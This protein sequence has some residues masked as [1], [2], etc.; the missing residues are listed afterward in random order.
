MNGIEVVDVTAGYGRR[1]TP[2]RVESGA[3]RAVLA[4][5]SARF[6][7]GTVTAI[8][9]PNGV[10]KTTLLNL[11]LGWMRPWEGAVIVDGRPVATLSGGERGRLLSLVPQSDHVPFEF[12]LLD[13]VLLGRAPHLGPLETPGREDVR[14]ALRALERVGLAD[15][16]AVSVL[17]MSAGERQLVLLARALAQ[18]SAF[19]LLDEPSAHLDLANKRRLVSMLRSLAANGTGVVLTTHEPD[20][21]AAS[22]DRV[23]MLDSGTVLASG[24]PDEVLTGPLLSRAYDTPVTVHRA[25]GRPV[26]IW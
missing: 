15:R 12:S 14:I 2:E 24:V 9:G 5:I 1:R 18:E 7:P 23:V 22:A 19:L 13:C 17:E 10:G 25:D 6:G 3:P 16:A 26:F 11:C 8:L 4:G 21:A 20:F